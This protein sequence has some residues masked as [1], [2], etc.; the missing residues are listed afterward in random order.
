M[1]EL[2]LKGVPIGAIKGV[3]LDKDGTISNSEVHLLYLAKARIKAAI[4][5]FRSKS[6]NTEE[7]SRLK[8]LLS[9]A[10]GISPQ[11]LNPGGTIAVASRAQNL[12]STATILCLLGESWP[13]ALELANE[14]FHAVDLTAQKEELQV[15]K[16]TLLPG[17]MNILKKLKQANI[18]CALISN[19][20]HAGIKNF[21]QT[22]QL[23]EFISCFWSADNDPPKP[24]PEAVLGLCNILKLHPEECA[25]VGDAESDLQMANRAGVDLT[26]G[27][28]AGWTMP[29]QLTAH[30]HIIKHWDELS[31]VK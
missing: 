26:L 2:L 9:S 28:V 23:E 19:D 13:K 14:I 24:H 16:R 6:S 5:I 7:L 10:Y 4:Q 15:P 8:N 18:S 29:P 17:V 11:G 12:I 21:L 27:Y 20:T 3:L 31:V 22:H 25:V 30:K 1:S